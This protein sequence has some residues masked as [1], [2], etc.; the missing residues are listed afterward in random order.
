[1]LRGGVTVPDLAGGLVNPVPARRL[2]CVSAK[3]DL[4]RSAGWPGRVFA[5]AEIRNNARGERERGMSQ[6]PFA[7]RPPRLPPPPPALG[8]NCLPRLRLL[9]LAPPLR[10][11]AS[12][13]HGGLSE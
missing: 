6:Q 9:R 1:M 7:P 5:M 13:A 11:Q 2:G 8:V 3:D 12:Q 10:R 4:L